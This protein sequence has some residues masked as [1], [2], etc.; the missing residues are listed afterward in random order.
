MAHTKSQ[1]ATRGNKESN[2][3]R[4]GVKLFGGQAAHVGNVIIRQNGTRF[5]PG[6]GTKLGRDYT[7][8]SMKEGIVN[9]IKRKGRKYVT[10][11]APVTTSQESTT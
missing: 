9:F 7:I 4:L 11:T 3:R 5:K 2:A 10:V 1:K 6:V 8:F